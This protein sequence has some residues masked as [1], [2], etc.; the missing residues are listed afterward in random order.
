MFHDLHAATQRTCRQ[1]ARHH[2]ADFRATCGRIDA[3]S[4]AAA[5]A[6]AP[7]TSGAATG[8]AAQV[9]CAQYSVE[10]RKPLGLLLEE[11]R[12]GGIFVA[13]VVQGG[14]ADCCGLVGKVQRFAGSV[15]GCGSP[16]CPALQAWSRLQK[17]G[18]S[19]T[20]PTLGVAGCDSRSGRCWQLHQRVWLVDKPVHLVCTAV[21]S[22]VDVWEADCC[23]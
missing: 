8:A 5:A 10:L 23:V 3:R 7:P 11:D 15:V 1:F 6:G 21:L 9:P 17:S 20:T 2:A 16:D 22:S 4:T 12:C 18:P 14:N 19:F 13:S